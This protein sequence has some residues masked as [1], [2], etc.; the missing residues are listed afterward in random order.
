MDKKLVLEI[1][2]EELPSS[3][4]HEGVG[5]LKTILSNKLNQNRIP[6]SSIRTFGTP[7]RLAAVVDGV[8]DM[9]KSHTRVVT[10]PP[11]KIAFDSNAKPSK[12]AIGFAKSL[13][14]DVLQLEEIETERGIYMGKNIHEEGKPAITVLPKLLKTSIT[15]INFLKQMA[16]GDYRL[17]FAR[18]IRWILA[19][20]GEEL[21][22][23]NLENLRAQKFTYGLRCLDQ[24]RVK[25]EHADHYKQRLEQEGLVVL[26]ASARKEMIV[27]AVAQMEKDLWK[28]QKMV[29]LNPDLLD[30][31]VNLVEYPRVL[32]GRFGS[33]Y[34]YIPKDILVKAIEYHQKYFAVTDQ[35]G[36]ITT[37]FVVVQNGTGDQKS[38]I[39][40]NQ[41]VLEA[42][43][44]D[45]VFFYEEDKKHDFDQWLEKLK[46]VIFYS[47]IGSMYDKVQRLQKIVA[48]LAKTLDKNAL[49][50]PLLKAA[51]ICKCD[52][53][54]NMVVEFPQLQGIVG[55]E[56]AT[57]KGEQP[58]V[59]EAV[60]EHH[61]PRFAGDCLPENDTGTILS[62]ADKL[63]TI[64]GM[65]L[66][67]NIPTGSEDPFA[68]RRKA[69]GMVASILKKDYALFLSKAV[70]F[71]V[72]LYEDRFDLPKPKGLEQ[73]I[74]DFILARYRFRLDKQGKRLDLVDAIAATGISSVTAID[75]RYKALEGYIS[76]ANIEH[77]ANPMIR[78]QNII[79]GKDIPA[80]NTDL[81]NQ[82]GERMLYSQVVK[83]KGILDA[84]AASED[85]A[86]LLDHLED[87][88]KA[89]DRFFDQ[90]LVMDKDP[91]IRKNRMSLVQSARDLFTRMADFS[92]LVI[93][94]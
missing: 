58:E 51:R 67:G 11:K 16:W 57:E 61:L 76:K 78:C 65:F 23:L 89:V 38:I 19:L 47:Q 24:N 73:Q 12:A 84:R 59:A 71:I 62:I 50:E 17:K 83:T 80:L 2:T 41:R 75:K 5:Q 14:L 94:G 93:E 27:N 44:S 36:G 20:F 72:G 30:E 35:K 31:V 40:G 13:G 70:G 77:I 21:I 18:P 10:G 4:I 74:L 33:N 39:K 8:S 66:L 56:Y 42:R 86:G 79:K 82:E 92:K 54:T 49:T 1:G 26:D 64:C 45:A 7:R 43:L 55:R 9:Q 52:L 28:N 22:P 3:C 6:F 88:G 69:S 90:V 91:A 81:F 32:A 87:F 60:F 68:L 34:L 53:V 15:E 46:G 63:D 25:I 85:Y 29:I 48:Y 37:S